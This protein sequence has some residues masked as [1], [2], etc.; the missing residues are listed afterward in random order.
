MA[1]SPKYYIKGN[2]SEKQ[3]EADVAS[4]F[5]WCTPPE[6]IF[7]FRLL[8]TDEQKTGADKLYDR[9][10][11]IYMQFKKSSGLKSTHDVRPSTRKGR[12]PLEGIREFR[13]KHDLEQDPTLFFQLRA[14]AKTASDLQHNV[15]LGYECPP[16]SRAIYVAPLLL[17]KTSYHAALHESTNRFLLDPFY[18]R[19]RHSI[20]QRHWTSYFGATPFLREHISIPPHERVADHNHYYAYSETGVDISWHSPEIVEREPSRLSDFIVKLFLSAINEPD[21][22]LPQG[23]LAERIAKISSDLGFQ[24]DNSNDSPIENLGKYGRW[25][26]D[27]HGIRQFIL[28]GSS[29]YI[30]KLR[31]KI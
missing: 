16:W 21:S 3:I 8:D 30:E 5:G 28:L 14:Q 29:K 9:A 25:L 19:I 22:M 10:T 7:P 18:Y 6:E 27:T 11:A 1:T 24:A 2:L 17:D 13:E 4:F 23:E 20:H 26:K 31:S 15:L 12:S